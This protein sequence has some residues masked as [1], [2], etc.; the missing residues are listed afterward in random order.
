MKKILIISIFALVSLISLPVA[1]GYPVYQGDIITLANGIG[2]TN[3]GEFI[4]SKSGTPLFNTFCLEANEYISFGTP[5]KVGS[6]D[7]GAILGGQGGPIDQLDFRTAYLFYHFAVGDLQ[8]YTYGQAASA[9]ALQNAIWYIEGEGGQN[10]AFV[11]LADGKWSDIGNVRV[12][13]LVDPNT[14][15][16]KQSVLTL[17]PEPM[18]ML[19]LGLGLVG[20]AGLRRKE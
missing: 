2:D 5:Y 10:N 16:N 4:L 6:I 20:L 11:T 14:G 1:F 18:T 17:V 13:N 15:E 3:G 8:G 19:L 12:L 9:D 7:T